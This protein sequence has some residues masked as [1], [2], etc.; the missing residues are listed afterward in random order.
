MEIF[1][2]D[3]KNIIFRLVHNYQYKKVMFDLNNNFRHLFENRILKILDDSLVADRVLQETKK[4]L[5]NNYR[6]WNT[7][8]QIIIDRD[9]DIPKLYDL[10]MYSPPHYY[11]FKI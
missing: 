1:P 4:F 7:K 2:K 8:I 10:C 3:V 9:Q 11:F 5:Y 6:G